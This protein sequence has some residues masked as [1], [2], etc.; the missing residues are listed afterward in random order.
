MEKKD[1]TDVIGDDIIIIPLALENETE[2]I[3]F[4]SGEK[5]Y[6]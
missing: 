6:D 5:Q 2:K 1:W 3:D 4:S